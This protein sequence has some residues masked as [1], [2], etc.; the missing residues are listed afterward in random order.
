MDVFYDFEKPIAQLEKRLKELR[1]INH[2]N[3]VDFSPE[4]QA[5]EKK[6]K[7]LIEEIYGKLNPWQ[8]VQVS[9]HPNRPYASD[10]FPHL[11]GSFLELHGDRLF[12]EDSAI[13]TGLT[14]LGQYPVAVVACQKGRNTKQKIERNFGM[15]K[16]E[17]YR[18]ALRIMQ[19][20]SR[21]ELPI[22]SFIDTPGAFPG[23]D[24]EE[25]GQS[26]AI[27]HSILE[28]FGLKCPIISCV[29]GEGGSGGALAIGISDR[30]L[31]QEYATYSV[32]SP[33]SCASIIWSDSSMN[34]KAATAMKMT[35]AELLPL[36]VVDEIVPEP[37]GG[38]HRDWEG[39]ALLLKKSLLAHLKDLKAQDASDLM[40]S[41]F[42]KFRNM[43]N[44]LGA[45][46][47][48]RNNKRKTK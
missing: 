46:N 2:Q 27:A 4:I 33:E 39:A 43:G 14:T 21:F 10:Y 38:A 13:I 22:L 6:L 16:P 47:N 19:L 41:R 40:D 24:A 31:I 23:V 34:E 45:K 28:M 42:L 9:R 26:E 37:L 7:A 12:G 35:A 36:G 48:T 11:F 44:P 17:G 29:I 32:I 3:G 30:T 1:E 15:A 8:K 25:R 5:L 18:K 20:A